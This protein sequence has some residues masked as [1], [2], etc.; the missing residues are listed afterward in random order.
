MGNQQS[1]PAADAEASP[2]PNEAAIWAAL[3]SSTLITGPFPAY[4]LLRENAPVW[5]SPTGYVAF[6]HAEGEEALD[7][8]LRCVDDLRLPGG[9]SDE[10]L[11]NLRGLATLPIAW[12]NAR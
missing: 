1:S 5:R 10:D 8:I 3:S 2:D 12:T 9:E 7:V 11:Y 6:S 4:A